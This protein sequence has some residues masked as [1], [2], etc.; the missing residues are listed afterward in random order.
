MRRRD[1]DRSVALIGLRGQ[2]RRR[3]R[4][5]A[6]RWPTGWWCR[7]WRAVRVAR[8]AGLAGDGVGQIQ[9]RLATLPGP[10]VRHWQRRGAGLADRR[11]EAPRGQQGVWI[12]A[13]VRER[14]VYEWLNKL[15]RK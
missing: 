13:E 9:P 4:G 14:R 11:I 6:R 12:Q 7:R 8:I 10:G 1:I 3:G 15:S 5:R 2:I